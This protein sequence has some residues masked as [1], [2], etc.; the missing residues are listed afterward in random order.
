M[1]KV[2]KGTSIFFIFS[3]SNE[4]RLKVEPTNEDWIAWASENDIDEVRGYLYYKNK[5]GL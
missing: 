3:C 2:F 4:E 5:K 1:H